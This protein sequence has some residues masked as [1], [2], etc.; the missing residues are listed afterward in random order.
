MAWAPESVSL[1]VLASA[2]LSALASASL[3]ALAS[4]SLL[5]P[6]LVSALVWVLAKGWVLVRI[7]AARTRPLRRTDHHSSVS[8]Q[9][10]D[11]LTR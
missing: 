2:S 1:L 3:L 8:R 10:P 9:P 7:Q 5:A 4:V 11:L 6:V